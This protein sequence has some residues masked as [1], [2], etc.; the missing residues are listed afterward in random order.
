MNDWTLPPYKFDDQD[1]REPAREPRSGAPE[2]PH[3]PWAQEPPPRDPFQLSDSPPPP[4]PPPTPPSG[5]SPEEPFRADLQHAA[6]RKKANKWGWVL[7][8]LA[9]LVLVAVPSI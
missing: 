1:P 2:T 4:P 8:T 9:A 5:P 7:G 3:D 6:S